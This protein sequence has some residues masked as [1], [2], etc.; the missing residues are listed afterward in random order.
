MT[1]FPEAPK[2]YSLLEDI[3]AYHFLKFIYVP[4]SCSI[5]YYIPFLPIPRLP[6][7]PGFFASHQINTN[8]CLTICVPDVEAFVRYF[9]S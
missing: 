9:P 7:P 8:F 5:L 4:G 6:L 1:L 2:F 3:S